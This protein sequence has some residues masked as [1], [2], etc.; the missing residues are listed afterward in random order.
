MAAT[1]ATLVT[2]R[3][4]TRDQALHRI[5]C[6][7]RRLARQLPDAKP[8]ARSELVRRCNVWL[9]DRLRVMHRPD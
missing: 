6:S 3:Q 4:E 1:A 2:G 5:D 7:L 8:G 9:D